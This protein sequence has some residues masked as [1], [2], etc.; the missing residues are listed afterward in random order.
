[1]RGKTNEATVLKQVLSKLDFQITT[2]PLPFPPC[3]DGGLLLQHLGNA[4]FVPGQC[5]CS[6]LH[7][8]KTALL[9][10]DISCNDLMCILLV[11]LLFLQLKFIVQICPSNISFHPT[12]AS[13]L[14]A[15]KNTYEHECV[16]KLRPQAPQ[17]PSL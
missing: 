17:W 10:S 14:D 5:S 13:F 8:S 2:L 4:F 11:F 6:F 9:L 12:N 7:M 15:K 16:S 3:G 1:M